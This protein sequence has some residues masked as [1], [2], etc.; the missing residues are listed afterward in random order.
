MDVSDKSHVV[1][2]ILEEKSSIP[3]DKIL[4]GQTVE[5][6][7]LD[8]LDSIEIIMEIED[9]F[10]IEIPDTHADTFI[11]ANDLLNYVEVYT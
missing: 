4:G 7:G 6:L 3:F 2:Q 5:D 1:L 11:T 8:S 10:D 9:A